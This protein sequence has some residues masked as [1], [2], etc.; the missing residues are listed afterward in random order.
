MSS[1]GAE[2]TATEVE[3]EKEAEIMVCASC[4]IA[5]VDDIKLEECSGC[6]LVKYCSD[7]CRENHREQHEAEC[8]KRKAELHDKELFEQPEES[9]FGECPLCLLPLSLDMTKSTFNS[10]CCKSMCNGCEYADA[11]S[12]G[13]GRCPFCREPA[14]IGEEENEK[15]VMERVKVNDPNA[16]RKMGTRRIQEGDYETAFEYYTK[17]AELGDSMA[18][19]QLGCSITVGK[20]SRRTRK[21]AF[22][23][24]KG[25][26]WW[27]PQC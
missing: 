2:G 8:R 4:G 22:I 11:I 12:N 10:C 26:Y 15:R 17:A 6:D 3:A 25:C 18:H 1:N 21:R 7:I 16:L 14:V 27:S 5:P 20:V 24:G 19:Y 13:G 23:I 9:H